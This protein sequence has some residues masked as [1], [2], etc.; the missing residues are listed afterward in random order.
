MRSG[1]SK[2]NLVSNPNELL[3]YRRQMAQGQLMHE[4][5]LGRLIQSSPALYRDWTSMAAPIISPLMVSALA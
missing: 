3:I 4:A 2:A 5:S 1:S